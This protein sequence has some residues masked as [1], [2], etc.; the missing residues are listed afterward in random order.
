LEEDL[1]VL[2]DVGASDRQKKAAVYT[3]ER[4]KILRSQ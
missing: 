1:A 3:S 2:E 4:K